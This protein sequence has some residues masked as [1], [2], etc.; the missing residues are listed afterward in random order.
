MKLASI[1]EVIS[2]SGTLPSALCSS[3]T[4]FQPSFVARSINT[5]GVSPAHD[6]P[7]CV[8]NARRTSPGATALFS[9]PDDADD[10]GKPSHYLRNRP[11]D[12]EESDIVG[13]LL[14]E[15][16]AAGDIV[17]HEGLEHL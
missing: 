7:G 15:Q 12:V 6:A 8:E 4:V 2:I 17:S 16:F 1:S 9:L 10:S 5:C 3:V 14:D 11:L 13:V